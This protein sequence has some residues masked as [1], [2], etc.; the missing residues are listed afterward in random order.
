MKQSQGLRDLRIW[1]S[2]A[3]FASAFAI[4][5]RYI[6]IAVASF[7]PNKPSECGKMPAGFAKLTP[8]LLDWVNTESDISNTGDS[9]ELSR[10]NFK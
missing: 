2:C 10:L 8:R 3:S 5:I 7:G 4:F 9:Q 1:T 6:Q